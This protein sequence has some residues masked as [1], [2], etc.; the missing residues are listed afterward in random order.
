MVY[1]IQDQLNSVVETLSDENYEQSL[2]LY[3]LW[4]DI[5]LTY[6]Q[7]PP[8]KIFEDIWNNRGSG[9][10][11]P[12]DGK[13]FHP[14]AH[15]VIRF[16]SDAESDNALAP[17]TAGLQSRLCTRTLKDF[18]EDNMYWVL[19]PGGGRRKISRYHCKSHRRLG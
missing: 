14:T 5:G 17:H 6:C 3:R 18:F 11:L 13:L 4:F 16:A 10:V 15:L 9:E 7:N 12:K 2:A 1:G 19:R 8:D